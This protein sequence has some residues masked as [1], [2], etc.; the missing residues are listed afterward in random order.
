LER[1]A[2]GAVI[3]FAI[4]YVGS[5]IIPNPSRR[6]PIFLAAI[7]FV[8]LCVSYWWMWSLAKNPPGYGY[9]FAY[10]GWQWIEF[11]LLVL[12]QHLSIVIT[13]KTIFVDRT[14]R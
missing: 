7:T 5:K 12:I 1:L 4:I 9:S 11:V 10:S 3:P 13:A 14:S 6:I 8:L 2:Q